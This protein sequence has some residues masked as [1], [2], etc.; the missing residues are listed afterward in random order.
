MWLRLSTRFACIKM[1]KVLLFGPW[2]WL[3]VVFAFAGVV[4][5]VHSLSL[6]LAFL[7][8]PLSIFTKVPDDGNSKRITNT[9]RGRT[10][11]VG[12]AIA[13][14]PALPRIYSPVREQQKLL[15]DQQIEMTSN[16]ARGLLTKKIY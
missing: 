10:M 2:W 5:F 9:S 11:V 15:I 7:L 14:T 16:L 3:T 6:L 12:E 13:V 1:V 4:F 8:L